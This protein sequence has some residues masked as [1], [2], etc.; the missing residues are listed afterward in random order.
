MLLCESRL[1]WQ[2][3]DF[4][5]SASTR[6][7]ST[8]SKI[9]CQV[10]QSKSPLGRFFRLSPQFSSGKVIHYAEQ[11][12]FKLGLWWPVDWVALAVTNAACDFR[13]AN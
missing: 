11:N 7:A 10:E 2:N 1:F 5:K 8:Q 3:N 13:L 12:I 4:T 6:T 9:L